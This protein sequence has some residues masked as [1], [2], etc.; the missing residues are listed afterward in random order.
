MTQM[1]T[2]HLER[3]LALQKQ[4]PHLAGVQTAGPV[5]HRQTDQREAEALETATLKETESK[6]VDLLTDMARTEVALLTEAHPKQMKRT[7]GAES[8]SSPHQTGHHVVMTVT[9]HL[10]LPEVTVLNRGE[11]GGQHYQQ[12]LHQ[13]LHQQSAAASICLLAQPLPR[14]YLPLS[15]LHQSQQ[16]MS[17]RQQCLGSSLMPQ[18]C[19]PSP[20][21]TPLGLLGPVKRC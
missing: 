3:S 13:Q 8:Q 4:T 17:H 1:M 10:A 21:A 7:G 2:G 12:R 9:A 16:L 20:K 11:Q 15:H 18:L 5:S 14:N 19:P 6:V